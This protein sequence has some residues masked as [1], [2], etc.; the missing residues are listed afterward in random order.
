M[1]S[2]ARM[3]R[4]NA[5][6]RGKDSVTDVLSFPAPEVFRAGGWLGELVICT[7]VMRR[8]AAE[9]GHA[10]ERELHVLVV[11]G[12]LHL[13]GFDHE[14]GARQAAEM[15]RWES[16]LL[17]AAGRAAGADARGLIRRPI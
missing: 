3:R 16:R 13:L 7:G 5:R 11:H 17:R 1:V 8:Q 9:L 14:K 12:L 15:A 4:L 2:P 10:P 6:F